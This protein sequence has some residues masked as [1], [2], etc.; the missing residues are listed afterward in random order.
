MMKGLLMP[1]LSKKCRRF[2]ISHW[3]KDGLHAVLERPVSWVRHQANPHLKSL[4]RK[5]KYLPF[6]AIDSKVN[7]IH[8]AL[9]TEHL[10]RK[11]SSTSRA[12]LR[13][14][15]SSSPLRSR[16]EATTKQGVGPPASASGRVG[17]HRR[18]WITDHAFTG[19]VCYEKKELRHA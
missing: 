4:R 13:E 8:L 17:N 19:V 9:S 10:L 18:R 7:R 15:C 5:R 11:C 3:G 2:V 14:R 12:A 1:E 16:S 6:I